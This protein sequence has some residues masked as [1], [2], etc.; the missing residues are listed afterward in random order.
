MIWKLYEQKAT[1][2]A[3]PIASGQLMPSDSISRNAPTRAMNRYV[4]GRLPVS[5]RL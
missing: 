4:A 2:M 5:S 3:P 1:A